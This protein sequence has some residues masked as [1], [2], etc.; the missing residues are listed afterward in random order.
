MK[1]QIKK[2]K[3]KK[4]KSNHF[5]YIFVEKPKDNLIVIDNITIKQEI[6]KVDE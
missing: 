6:I 1:K 4:K 5:E 3:K 2:K